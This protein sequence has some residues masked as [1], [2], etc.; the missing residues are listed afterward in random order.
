VR[1]SSP[2]LILAEGV[3]LIVEQLRVSRFPVSLLKKAKVAL[4]KHKIVAQNR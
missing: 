1:N 4:H 2:V 3:G